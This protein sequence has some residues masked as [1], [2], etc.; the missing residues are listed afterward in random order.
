[1]LILDSEKNRLSI[2]EDKLYGTTLS[3]NHEDGAI[4]ATFVHVPI[5]KDNKDDVIQLDVSD[6]RLEETGDY[7]P[8]VLTVI[9]TEQLIAFLQNRLY[10]LKQTKER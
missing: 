1:M 2:L 6:F 7:T 5:T 3:G 4:E 10:L 9:E 8:F